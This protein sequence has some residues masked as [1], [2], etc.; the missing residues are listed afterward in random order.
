MIRNEDA[1]LDLMNK[2]L[3]KEQL[4]GPI[5]DS[6]AYEID[7]KSMQCAELENNQIFKKLKQIILKFFITREE[8]RRYG[9]TK[10]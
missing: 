3:S 1:G 4:L 10:K 6:V 7:V 8:N 2:N 9:Q 5:T